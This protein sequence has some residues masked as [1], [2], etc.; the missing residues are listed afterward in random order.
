MKIQKKQI[1]IEEKKSLIIERI[2][3]V[4]DDLASSSSLFP[5]RRIN[6]LF[7][8][9]V[10]AV[11]DA[12]KIH[13]DEPEKDKRIKKIIPSL[14]KLCSIGE[15]FLE[16]KWAQDI[17]AADS[18]DRKMAGF[19]YIEYY[20][21]LIKEEIKAI[22]SCGITHPF[23]MLFIGSGPLP[24]SGIILSRDY[25][26]SVDMVDKDK[27]ACD[28]SREIIKKLSLEKSIRVIHKDALQIEDISSYNAIFVAA[29]VG[30]TVLEKREILK[31]LSLRAS[32]NTVFVIR[33][34]RGPAMLLYRPV[35]EKSLCEMRIE[36]II[37]PED[38]V[39]NSTIIARKNYV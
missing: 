38:D 19:P 39:I 37:H 5:S 31:H 8:K 12:R 16:K 33:S 10:S 28:L 13:F 27:D 32:S 20:K 23:R 9:L 21:K 6:G 1:N 22:S 25:G 3:K 34:S 26:V 29:L 36:K 24:L 30:N 17:V 4:H 11:L 7:S 35:S 15:Y 2:L 18:G 14:Q